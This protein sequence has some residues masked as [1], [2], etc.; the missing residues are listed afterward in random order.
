MEKKLDGNCTRMLRALLNRSW[1]QHPIKQQLYRH[2]SPISKTIPIRWTIHAGYCWRSKLE[3]IN[4][5][6]LWTPSHGRAG[7]G[8]PVRTYLQ[9]VCKGTWCSL[10]DLP[11]AMDHKDEWR[12]R[13]REVRACGTIWWWGRVWSWL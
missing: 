11:N 12:G 9:Q 4:D 10:K 1:K 3:L 13:V 6:H 7:V 2:L 5:V 8:R